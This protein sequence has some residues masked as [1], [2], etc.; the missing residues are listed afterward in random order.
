MVWNY[1]NYPKEVPKELMGQFLSGDRSFQSYAKWCT[2]ACDLFKDKGLTRGS[3]REIVKPVHLTNGFSQT[4]TTLKNQGFILAIISGGIDVFLHEFVP[5]ADSVF[6]YVLINKMAFD[7]NGKLTSV[8]PT[9]YDFDGK[10]RALEEICKVNGYSL[11][12]AVFVG[13]GFNDVDV[14]KSVR[15]KGG[16]AIAYPPS[17]TEA[18]ALAEVRIEEDDL[19]LIL[20]HVLRT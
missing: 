14:I 11:A 20:S 2:Q 13:E 10:A 6:D 8:V 15:R 7:A 19:S 4:I 17:T 9:S 16:L 1:L 12:E 3:F 5:D 18:D